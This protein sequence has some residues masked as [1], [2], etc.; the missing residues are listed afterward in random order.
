MTITVTVMYPNTPGS[1]FDL[2]YYLTTHKELVGKTMGF[3]I[4]NMKV[5]KALGTPDPD[6]A[7]PFQIMAILEFES[8]ETLHKAMSEHS[9]EVLGDIPNF[10][11]IKP[12][13][14]FSEN[15]N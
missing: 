15:L 12:I 2:D 11:D 5:I 9:E 1:N 6:A 14:Q 4:I 10:T 13:V 7:A 3:S 8:I